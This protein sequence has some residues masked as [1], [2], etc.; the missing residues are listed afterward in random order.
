MRQIAIYDLDKTLTRRPTFTPFLMFAAG[1]AGFG[2]RLLLPLWVLAMGG[3]KAGLYSRTT[4]KTIGMRL[5]VGRRTPQDLAHVG[6]QFAE[7]HVSRSGTMPSIMQLLEADMREDKTVVIATAAFDFYARAFATM[8]GIENVIATRWEGHTIPG[9]NCYG[10]EKHA[11]VLAWLERTA[12]RREDVHVRFVSDS[13]AD[14]PLLDEAD[15]PIFVS[16]N[17]SKRK[18][19]ERRGWRAIDGLYPSVSFADAPEREL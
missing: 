4:L 10:P 13:F 12:G 15:E 16:S 18:Q 19:A 3:Y 14:A 9:G 5:M 11:R 1:Q 8:F 7:R 17:A 6:S 2:R